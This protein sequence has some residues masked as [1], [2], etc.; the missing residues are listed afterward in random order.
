MR[1]ASF[2]LNFFLVCAGIVLGAM[3]AEITAGTAG[4]EWLSYGLN[5][6]TESPV[7]LN[8]GVLR[9]TFGINFDFT[10]STALCIGITLLLGRLIAR[11]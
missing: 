2:W 6:G 10:I 3:L 8:L 5:F 7:V 11:R 1:S 9:L 4:L